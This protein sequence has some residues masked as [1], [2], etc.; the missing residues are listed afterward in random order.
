MTKKEIICGGSTAVTAA[1]AGV[2]IYYCEKLQLPPLTAK[3]MI[4]RA[5]LAAF[6]CSIL[7]CLVFYLLR[8]TIQKLTR[9]EWIDI[10]LLSLV[11]SVCV[12]VWFPVP[13]TG[14][15]PEHYLTVRALPD[16][17]GEVCPVT[18]TWLHRQDRDISLKTVQ[19]SEN[20]ELTENSITLADS[21]AELRWHGITGDMIT[22]EFVSGEDRG[23]AGITWDGT[24]H[25]KALSNRDMDRLS[26]DFTF[27]PSE[28]LPEFVAV[29]WICF[30][31][32]L[33]GVI[34]ALKRF[35]AWNVKT[36]GISVFMIFIVFR[37][38][39]FLTVS[40]PLL[41]IDSG[42]YIGLSHFSVKEILGGAEYCRNE[43]H[44]LSRPVLIP[45]VYKL[46]QQDLKVITIVQ[47]I[48]SLISWGYFAVQASGLLFTNNWKKAVIFLTL[49][50]G[51]IPNVTRWDTM[52][53]SESLSIS[54]AVLFLGSLFWLTAAST[55]QW[56]IIPAVCTLFSA[57]LFSVSRD[58]AVW[59]VIP[60]I[61]VLLFIMR[62]RGRRWIL[63]GLSAVLAVMAVFFLSKT[64]D[65]WI[66]SFENVLFS[67]ILRDPQG[68][69]LMIEAGMPTPPSI[70]Q[71]Y[72]T[73]HLMASP[74]F[75]SDEY[76]P[77]RDWIRSD[78]LKAYIRYMLKKPFKTLRMTWKGGFEK[79]A[80][81]SVGYTFTPAGFRQLLPDP[82]LKFFSC[83]F[84]G[85]LIFGLS[86]AG[87]YAAFHS[88]SGER[89]SFPV[90]FILSAYLLC[91]AAYI[92]DEY[93]LDRHMM[94]T[95][96]MMKGSVWPLICML[97][98]RRSLK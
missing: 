58:S 89:Y 92:A 6:I 95:L 93:E 42:F 33:A 35:P 39:Q 77:L 87:I 65:R 83:S 27:P 36:F 55:H 80:F 86:L 34:T 67:R 98:E 3:G 38:C 78:G 75:N 23:I 49:G 84:P 30:L 66:Y 20:C 94:A 63:I 11:T 43:W 32:S 70:E 73:E 14:L 24:A 59:A 91:T 26:F 88:I 90:L 5:A 18:L 13:D 37:V 48:V 76:Q 53:M 71:L 31:I 4:A 56:K 9:T 62:T 8:K 2:F 69:A 85:V 1:L 50:L 40:E 82:I 61:L 96:T 21:D 74:L 97:L 57:I 16:E 52:I 17:D 25:I 51:C 22:V 79:Y 47:M 44:C 46:C 81:E 12:M 41:F 15:Y 72:G 45:L 7:S 60:V 19:C 28:G 29:W 54:T 68:E 10:L 64:G